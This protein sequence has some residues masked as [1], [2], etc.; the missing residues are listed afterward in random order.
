MAWMDGAGG[1]QT[2][3][4]LGGRRDGLPTTQRPTY[5]GWRR[6]RQ[7][8][9]RGE[10]RRVA[11]HAAKLSAQMDSLGPQDGVDGVGGRM[12]QGASHGWPAMTSSARQHA[13][14]AWAL[15]ANSDLLADACGVRW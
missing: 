10:A 4:Q 7:R 12:R 9:R 13:A 11:R 1:K 3:G 2:G 14:P 15:G 8:A 5:R 6:E